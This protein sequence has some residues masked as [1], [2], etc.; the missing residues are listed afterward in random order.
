MVDA[1]STDGWTTYPLLNKGRFV[2]DNCANASATCKAL[3]SIMNHLAPTAGA[4]EVGVRLN[5]LLPGTRLRSHRGPG[6][7]LVA[8]LG[9][10]VPERGARLDVDGRE[11][12]WEE[13]KLI[14]FDDA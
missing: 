10:T 1:G 6:N 13:G 8:H 12:H 7:R 3:S 11:M 14:V 2:G 5:R 4:T 9:V